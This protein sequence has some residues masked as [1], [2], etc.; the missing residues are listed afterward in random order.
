MA[1]CRLTAVR[2]TFDKLVSEGNFGARAGSWW[3]R[4][5]APLGTGISALVFS[6]GRMPLSSSNHKT[7]WVHLKCRFGKMNSDWSGLILAFSSG[8]ARSVCN[9]VET[10]TTVL[11]ERRVG[12]LS[13]QCPIVCPPALGP[14]I[15]LRIFWEGH[16]A[17]LWALSFLSFT[18][19]KLN[20]VK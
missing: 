2:P 6:V 7:I 19:S 17:I 16:I 15:T 12:W 10:Y 14:W 3:W 5:G 18:F 11:W 4:C 8:V 20:F 1:P 13:H 9:W